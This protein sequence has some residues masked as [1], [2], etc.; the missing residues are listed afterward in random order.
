MQNRIIIYG[1]LHGC[2]EEFIEL[3]N[4]INP[5][6]F[7]REIVLGDILDKGPFEIE[8]LRYLRENKIESILGNHEDKYIRYFKHLKLFEETGKE[9]EVKLS[10]SQSEL[11]NK[12]NR[13]DLEYLESF[14]S[15]LKIENLTLVHGGLTNDIDL[16]NL[17]KKDIKMIVRLRYLNENNIVSHVNHKNEYNERWAKFYDGNQGIVVYGHQIFDDVMY[18]KFSI[19]IDTGCVYGNKLSAMI[20]TDTKNPMENHQIVKVDAKASYFKEKIL[21][22]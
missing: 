12:L 4:K 22:K 5:T 14:P 1:D 9:I 20:V 17:S 7:D 18:D 11:F 10:A 21:S 2:F 15:F 6:V 19:G 16:E 13:N 3:R 8:L